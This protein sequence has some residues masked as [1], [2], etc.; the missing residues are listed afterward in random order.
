MRR[1]S[2]RGKTQALGPHRAPDPCLPRFLPRAP[3][4]RSPKKIMFQ[5]IRSARSDPLLHPMLAGQSTKGGAAQELPHSSGG[6]EEQGRQ[7]NFATL[8]AQHRHHSTAHTP[9]HLL[10]N[11]PHSR[12]TEAHCRP[13]KPEIFPITET[14][15][16]HMAS[17]CPSR[18]NLMLVQAA[19]PAGHLA[20]PQTGCLKR[21]LRTHVRRQ[22][23]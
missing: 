7:G 8:F 20:T 11:S 5:R 13:S 14:S 1:D 10:R 4:P 21:H 2:T 17:T 15:S 19:T 9:L 23:R 3:L 16:A 12:D 18:T 22:H 6:G